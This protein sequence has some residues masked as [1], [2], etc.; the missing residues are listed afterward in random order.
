MLLTLACIATAAG[1]VVGAA[2]KGGPPDTGSTGAAQVLADA[3]KAGRPLLLFRSLARASKGQPAFVPLDR[4]SADP[5]LTPMNCDRVSFA[6]GTGLCLTR[7]GGF[8]RGYE[9]KVF[10]ERLTS[11]GDVDVQGI[12]SRA[13][14]APDGRHGSV[15]LF[16]SGHTYTEAG[17]FST[18]TTLI[19]LKR[20][21]KLANL[22]DFSVSR[23]ARIVTAVDQN[24]WGTTFAADGDTFY[25]TLA[26]GGKTYL[27]RGSLRERTMRTLRTNVE[28]PALSPDDTRVA[29]KKR[30]GGGD[31]P[32]QLHVLDLKTGRE[33]ALPGTAGVD[34]QAEW[35]DARTVIYG[36]R[37]KV[38][39]VPADGSGPPR[40]LR[41][42]ADSPTVIRW[43]RG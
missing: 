17:A 25:A 39:A 30:V 38:L 20:R 41:D 7:G 43:N 27:V 34:D 21:E 6:G 42:R 35:L 8:A 23:N 15:T 31:R 26:T 10:G 12:A 28:C 4:P 5:V 22:E 19:D 9:A 3:R 16:V 33:T 1:A 14:V 13:R 11:S 40:V 36:D 18:E 37:G 29:F 24:Y 2:N 32:W